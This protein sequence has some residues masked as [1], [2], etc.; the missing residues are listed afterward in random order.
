MLHV[1]LV[2]QKSDVGLGL[3]YQGQQGEVIKAW[4]CQFPAEEVQA[5]IKVSI[6]GVKG[7]MMNKVSH[8][9]N[10]L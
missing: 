9:S 1:I 5:N 8:S 6:D 3:N 7:C 10:L 4:L 2:K